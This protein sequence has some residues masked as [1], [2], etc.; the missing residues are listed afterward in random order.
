MTFRAWYDRG[1]PDI[2]PV[3]PPDGKL[4]PLSK[5]RP[6]DRGKTPG[7]L[8]QHG[9]WTGLPHW[10]T[11]PADP[12]LWDSWPQANVGLR[13][14]QFPALDIDITDPEL[15]ARVA[16]L[17]RET[18]GPAPCRGRP[19]SPKRTLLYRTAEP[20]RRLRMWLSRDNAHHLVEML[21]DGQ[22]FVAD[23]RHPSGVLWTWDI[24][25]WA[26]ALTVI[27]LEDVLRFFDRLE[28]LGWSTDREGRPMLSSGHGHVD[29]ETLRGD[30]DRVRAA[31][32]AIPNTNAFFPGRDDYLKMGYAI[33]AALPDHP[34][35]A[36]SL[37]W[38]WCAKWEGNARVAGNTPEEARR[39]WD[40]MVPP[41]S[42]GASWLYE[43]ARGHGLSDAA[44]DFADGAVVLLDPK[45]APG[46]LSAP[47]S[48]GGTSGTT[49]GVDGAKFSDAWVA[50]HVLA[51]VPGR[52]R[53]CARLGGWLQWDGNR[54]AADETGQVLDLIGTV[55]REIGAGAKSASDRRRMGSSS[56]RHAVSDYMCTTP[57][58]STP[59]SAF[60][61]DPWVLNTPSGMVD[62]RTG[63]LLPADPVRLFTR[64]TAV[65]P[66]F[67]L[68]TPV[69]DRFLVEVTGG[70]EE[71]Q[72]YLKRLAGYA[73][74]GSTREHVLAFFW[75]PGGNGK[76][77]F[78]NTL[79]R[80]LGSYAVVAAMDTFTSSRFDRHPTELA[81][82]FGARLVT[83]QETQEG[84]N[85]DEARVKGITGGDPITARFMRE[86]F[87]TYTPQFKLLFA[88]NH[89]PHIANLDDAMRRRFHLIP[90]VQVPPR[91]DPDLPEKLVP[92]WPGIL[93]WAVEG[94]LEWQQHGL[95]PASVIRQATEAYFVDEDV[96]GRWL[97]DTTEPRENAFIE[98]RDLWAS[99][100]LWCA[101]K[102]ERVGSER[103]FVHRLLN[104]GYT[105]ATHPKTRRHGVR[106]LVLKTTAGE[107]PAIG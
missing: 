23:G 13:T 103:D 55:A 62:L 70:D 100:Q 67:I 90:F 29:Q 52:L 14:A 21:G 77:V 58:V 64:C 45:D 16:D 8:N 42:V 33:K 80:L 78:L 65:A 106:N 51:R 44:L 79:V 34:N 18:L 7:R 87:F 104:R 83:A 59:V 28:T 11:I 20:F 3:I 37:F 93:A 63:H 68:P 25:P 40:R 97:N 92:E 61:S 94:C 38:E 2:V 31:V 6:E 89:K 88:G 9:L 41:Y 75:G 32:R 71:L 60:D 95:V 39:D 22:Q 36:W 96:L 98:T 46:S 5:I 76:G 47:G 86:N 105:K 69:F 1:F 49:A 54:W 107:L 84:R 15:A 27:S 66:D 12:G 4:S 17:A 35:E 24:L 81:A 57:G 19:N 85:W 30:L 43:T 56:L 91:R 73:L 82:L 99:W 102:R 72:T 50:Q 10:Q 74:T 53:Y 26:E 101:E 48:P